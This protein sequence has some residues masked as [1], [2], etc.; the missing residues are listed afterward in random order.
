MIIRKSLF[1]ENITDPSVQIDHLAK[2][3]VGI[4]VGILRG[5]IACMIDDWK[6]LQLSYEEDID[7]HCS[8]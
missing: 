6:D 2:G 4:D 3:D 8:I 5:K 1:Q 7:N